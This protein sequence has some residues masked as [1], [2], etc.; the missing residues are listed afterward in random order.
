VR[1]RGV[2][3]APASGARASCSL[4]GRIEKRYEVADLWRLGQSSTAPHAALTCTPSGSVHMTRCCPAPALDQPALAEFCC[5]FGGLLVWLRMPTIACATAYRKSGKQPR[6][7][8]ALSTS[9]RSRGWCRSWRL[10]SARL[11][12]HV[13]CLCMCKACTRA[14]VS[15]N[16]AHANGLAVVALVCWRVLTACVSVV[17]GLRCGPNLPVSAL[18]APS[19]AGRR[20]QD[21]ADGAGGAGASAQGTWRRR[22]CAKH[23]CTHRCFPVN[24]CIL[25]CARSRR[26]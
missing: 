24:P 8:P 4:A 23:A 14:C 11:A 12:L 6:A 9:T 3:V 1:T 22:R 13:W 20:P 10:R 18:C 2:A 15:V 25:I 5:L 26:R 16:F 19:P 21:G 7:G 17:D